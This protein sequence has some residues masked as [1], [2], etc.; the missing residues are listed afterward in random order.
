MPFHIEINSPVDRTRVLNLDQAYLREKVLVPWV[1]GLPF[2]FEQGEWSAG[3]SRLTI[4]EG[5]TLKSATGEEDW[6]DALR[7]A[8]DVT[9]EMLEAAEA[10]APAQTAVVVEANSAETAL[11]ALRAGR[12][13]RQI[14]WSTAAERVGKHDPEVTAVILVVRRPDLPWPRLGSHPSSAR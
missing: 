10:S 8:A 11:E 14:P 4:L 12:P 3:E 5:P 1:A 7:T 9:R 13:T 2:E 6:A